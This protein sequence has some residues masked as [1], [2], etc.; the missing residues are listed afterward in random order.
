MLT[1]GFK[2]ERGGA[3]RAAMRPMIHGRIGS[4]ALL[5]GYVRR[6]RGGWR[7]DQSPQVFRT[8]T[9]AAKSLVRIVAG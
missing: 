5:V 6:V 1:Y 8:Q 7:N 3:V 4:D 9:D 2:V